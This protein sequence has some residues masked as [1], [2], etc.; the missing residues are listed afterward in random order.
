MEPVGVAIGVLGLAGLFSSCL[1]A[2]EKVQS[3]RTSTADS[4]VLNIR[5]DATKVRFERWGARVGINQLG[6]SHPHHPALDDKNV[7][8][9]VENLLKLINS[10][11]D[12]SNTASYKDSNSQ[13]SHGPRGI[14]FDSRRRRVGWALWGKAARTE[15]VALFETLV[16]QLHDL[17]PLDTTEGVRPAHLPGTKDANMLKLGMNFSIVVGSRPII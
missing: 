3:Y 11:D 4:H 6:A 5:F 13:R 9:T 2:V 16:Q 12:A 8:T 7:C 1:E 17:V 15:Q 10:I 14:A